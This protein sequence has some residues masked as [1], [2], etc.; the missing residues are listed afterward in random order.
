MPVTIGTSHMA[1]LMRQKDVLRPLLNIHISEKGAYTGTPLALY[2]INRIIY[3]AFR[4]SL[5]KN[6]LFILHEKQHPE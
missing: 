4:Y 1:Y 3:T 2:I 6:P 5:Y